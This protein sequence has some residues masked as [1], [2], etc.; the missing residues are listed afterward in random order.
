MQND[1]VP[2]DELETARNYLLGRTSTQ[3]ETPEQLSNSI[4][5]YLTLGVPFEDFERGFDIIAQTDTQT[6]RE[7]AQKHWRTQEMIEV[8]AGG[9]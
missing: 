9:A 6:V 3:F 8:T 2:H 1:L 5:H 4:Q 7:T